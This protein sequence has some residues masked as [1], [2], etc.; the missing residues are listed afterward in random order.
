MLKYWYGSPFMTRTNSRESTIETIGILYGR[1][2]EAAHLST[3]PLPTYLGCQYRT[4][5]GTDSTLWK[6]LNDGST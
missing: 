2:L 4:K 1:N 6:A 3:L 5:K